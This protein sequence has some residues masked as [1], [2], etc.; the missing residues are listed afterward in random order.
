MTDT[1]APAWLEEL[2]DKTV[3]NFIGRD[4]ASHG[5][6]V[7]IVPYQEGVR[8]KAII[9]DALLAA[10]ERPARGAADE[11]PQIRSHANSDPGTSRGRVSIDLIQ[12]QSSSMGWCSVL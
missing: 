8:L 6:I 4:F 9:H 12:Y 2:T 5:T 1:K 7:L 10:I 11:P 3:W